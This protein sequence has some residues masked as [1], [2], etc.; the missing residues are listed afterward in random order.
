MALNWA[1]NLVTGAAAITKEFASA[2]GFLG[3][4]SPVVSASEDYQ[5]Y[6]NWKSAAVKAFGEFL[7]NLLG[8][9]VTAGM[10]LV[11]APAILATGGLSALGASAGIVLTIKATSAITEGWDAL[12][13]AWFKHRE[14]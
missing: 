12:V 1:G 8:G 14:G 6:H 10:V 3:Y 9:A 11:A 4:A 13:D 7:I 2:N 5:R